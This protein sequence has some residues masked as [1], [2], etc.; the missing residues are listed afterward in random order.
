MTPRAPIFDQ[1]LA[2]Y[3]QKVKDIDDGT[4]RCDALGVTQTQIGFT[5]PL[6]N[7]SI[8]ITADRITDENGA[9]PSHSACVLACQYLLL[10][11][12]S[13]Q[14]DHALVT[15]KDFKDAAPYV[16]GFKNT[17]EHAISKA[18]SGRL[19]ALEMAC[20]ALNGQLFDTDVACQLA[21]QFQ[22]LPR[23]PIFLL[24]NDADDDFPAQC[25]LLFWKDAASY[26]DMECL[27]MIGAML[28]HRLQQGCEVC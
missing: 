12:K 16:I 23:V 19:H 8:T 25:T 26:L 7:Q 28:A 20:H 18:F 1:I 24:F 10:C 21:F 3:R 15:Y 2:D 4:R 6:F 13:P 14:P 5:V 11:P 17:A 27:A 22:A 9:S